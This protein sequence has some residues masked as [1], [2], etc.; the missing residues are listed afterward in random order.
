MSNARHY[1]VLGLDPGIASCG[2]CLLDMTDHKILEMGSHLFDA[3]QEAKTKV[4]LAVTRRNARSVRRNNQRTKARLAHCLRLLKDAGLVPADAD[5]TWFQ[6]VKKDKPILKLRAA[7]LDRLLSDREFAQVLYSLC[8]NRGYIPHGEGRLGET[9]DAEGKK[10]LGAIKKNSEAMAESGCRTVGEMLYRQGRSRNK[11]GSYDLCVLNSQIQDE[12]RAL[13]EA[14]RRFGNQKAAEELETEYLKCLTW[15]KKTTEHD[16]RSY[17]LVGYCPYFPLEKHAAL[18]DPSSELCRAYEKLKHLTIVHGDGSESRLSSEQVDGY[19]KLLFSTSPITTKKDPLEVTY[20]RIRKDLDLSSTSVFKGI[21]SEKEKTTEV[22]SPKSWR[23]LRRNG[24]PQALLQRMLD[25]RSLGDAICEALTFASSEES[26]EQQLEPLDLTE[27]EREA[28]LGVPFT[29]KLFKGYG[30]RSRKALEMLIDA[31]EDEGVHTLTEAERASGLLDKRRADSGT[32]TELL[33]AYDTYDRTCR[34][35]VVLRAMGR[36]RRIVNAIIKIYGVPDEIHI[37]LGRDLKQSKNEKIQVSKRQAENKAAN[38]R[39]AELAAGILGCTPE[40]VPGKIVQKLAM[41]EEQGEKDLYTGEAIDLERLVKEDH[42]CQ[43]DHILPYSR[44][45]DD[46]RANKVLVLAKSNQDKRERTPYEWMNSGETCA[47]DWNEFQAR[48]MNG[49]HWFRKRE[50]F[51]NTDLGPETEAKFIARNLNDD[52]YMSV[53][54]KNYLEDC[55]LFPEDGRKR[56]VTAVAGG[57]TGN[58]RWVWG[59]NF[60]DNGKKD[61]EDDRHHAVDAAI[62]AACSE[63][64]VRK[65][66]DASKLGRETFKHLRQSRLADTQP[67]PTFAEEVVERREQVIPTRMADHGVTGRAFE[68]TLYHLEGFTDDK[69]RYPLVRAGGKTV[70]KGNVHIGADGSARL[71]DG[72][73][74][75]RLWLDPSARPTGKVKG[76]WYAEPVYYADI[77][78]MRDG[79]Y[80]PRA[81]M[82]HVARVNWEPVPETALVSK[83]VTVFFGDVLK[84]DDH[85]GRFAGLNIANCSL[86]VQ[87]VLDKT[88]LSDW[89]SFG[90]W[91][92]QTQV[93]ILQED[94]LGHCYDG[95]SINTGASTYSI[96]EP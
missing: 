45:C 3:P 22:F 21:D 56:H 93:S 7:G 76:K 86:T 78:A 66:A 23:C 75:V 46:S 77:P 65:V 35:P 67:W 30:S 92:N 84:V 15:E 38:K 41:R 63:S 73:A 59:L 44:T 43:I 69:G 53:A 5:K 70:K 89:P 14:Q 42:Y 58:L 6:T 82:I 47:P 18:A 80:V 50:R 55:L 29:G 12:A 71:V 96:L 68:D 10:V 48:I 2:F 36:M 88:E 79:T 19:L 13:F 20:K 91:G 95:L 28:I 81:C 85:I 52:R 62:I 94:C 17:E 25:D 9:D 27:S 31:F 54:V 24:V 40:E 61:R 57:A 87:S 34:N 4:S 33:P 16:L 1:L 8:G 51:L 49:V 72:M 90:S 37:E 64:T 39:M 74:F 60:G 11:Q 32:R 83:P 26:L